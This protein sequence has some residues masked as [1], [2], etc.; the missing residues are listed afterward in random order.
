MAGS[1]EPELRVHEIDGGCRLTLVGLTHGD[2]AT[3]QEAADDLFANVLDIVV[4]AQWS[5]I[6]LPAGLGPPDRRMVRYI[7]G[8]VRLAER[9]DD[10]RGRL[11]GAAQP[12]GG[13][14]AE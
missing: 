7:R 5:G 9:G 12:A 13:T 8:L 6:R 11:F 3:L 2:G 10:I 4:R 14:P 1:W